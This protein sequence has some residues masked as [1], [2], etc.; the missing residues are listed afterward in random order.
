M[1]RQAQKGLIDCKMFTDMTIVVRV[2]RSSKA[3]QINNN[4]YFY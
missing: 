2:S 1:G 3:G 4:V